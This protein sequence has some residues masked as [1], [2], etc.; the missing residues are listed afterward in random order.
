M[1]PYVIDANV[2]AAI[3]QEDALGNP[4]PLS[5]SALSVAASLGDTTVALL[6][7]V[8]IMEEE[9]RGPVDSEWFTV[10]LAQL[11]TT[12]GAQ[13]VQPKNDGSLRRSLSSA[14]FP[15]ASRDIWYV[16]TAHAVACREEPATIVT[17]DPD[18]IDPSAKASSGKRS[19]AIRG[20]RGPVASVLRRRHIVVS[21]L[22]RCP[23]NVA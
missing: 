21:S 12:G 19:R 4:P 23:E 17:E 2:V 14:G 7:D 11:F 6:D 3:F 15:V 13:L 9:W 16:R 18:F 8:G 22:C 1:R 10:W 5:A 20:C